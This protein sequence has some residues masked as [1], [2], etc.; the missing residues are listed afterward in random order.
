MNKIKICH[1]I[2]GF[3]N[4]G[5]EKVLENYFSNI[6]RTK[7]E[8]HIVTHIPPDLK[9][10]K[11]FKDMGFIVHQ[12]SYVQ[13]HRISKKNISEYRELFK[14]NKFDIVHNHFPENLLPLLFARFY[15]IKVRILHSHGDYE[16]AFAKKN[17]L[18]K[19]LYGI[20]LRFNVFN[21]TVYFACGK[22]AGESVFGKK[23]YLDGKIKIVNNAIN[24]ERFRYDVDRRIKIRNEL[25]LDD[26][27]TLGHVGRYEDVKQK[28][29]GFVLQIFQEVLKTIPNARLL[30]LG[31][32]KEHVNIVEQAEKMKIKNKIIFTGAVPNVPDYLLAMDIFVFPSKFEGFSVATIEAQCSGLPGVIADTISEMDILGTFDVLSLNQPIQDWGEAVA[33]KEG[34]IR[35]DQSDR[36]RA[37]GYDIKEEAKKLEEFYCTCI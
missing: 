35:N 33:S 6:D 31:D 24:I 8:L 32:G 20:G 29:Q 30:M 21:A 9:R 11:K 22:K 15:N 28:N 23:N 3:H 17:V 12:L 36:I 1:F 37:K 4:G 13:G 25:G 2:L 27:F 18:V 26:E 10:E 14:E 19:W 5:V 34:Y 16:S 7:F